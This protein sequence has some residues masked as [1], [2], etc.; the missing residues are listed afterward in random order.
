VPTS[1]VVPS[2][3]TP[4]KRERPG[5]LEGER[6]ADVDLSVRV[7]LAIEWMVAT[8]LAVVLAHLAVEIVGAALL[9]Y[10][11]LF[12]LPFIGG[13][14]G[15]LPV[16]VLQWIVLR[17]YAGDSRSW[18]VFTLLGFVGAWT[19]AV[20]LAA[21]LFVPRSGLDHFRTFLSFAIPTPIIGLSQSRVLRR[22]SRHTRFW[23]IA[24]TVGWGGFV[25]VEF[26]GNQSLPAVD[27]LGGRLVSGLAGYTVASNVGATLLAGALAGAITGIALS[28]TMPVRPKVSDKSK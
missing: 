14:V 11:L 17:R 16:G 6:Y 27:Q 23:A 7:L 2:W 13:V 26:F 5:E 3:R 18:I 20:I 15:G 25:A 22:W 10:F 21:A 12:F 4:D 28:I 1:P 8:T 24:S 9:G 19:V